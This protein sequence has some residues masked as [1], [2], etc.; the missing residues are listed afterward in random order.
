LEAI[1]GG[2]IQEPHLAYERFEQ[3]LGDEDDA[4]RPSELRVRGHQTLD[5]FGI[6]ETPRV[7]FE[8]SHEHDVVGGEAE[9]GQNRHALRVERGKLDV[10][11]AQ[12]QVGREDLEVRL[13][14]VRVVRDERSQL[15]QVR[16]LT[17][18]ESSHRNIPDQSSNGYATAQHT[19]ASTK[20]TRY[21]PR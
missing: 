6:L 1:D 11:A 8:G 15:L 19:I 7:R 18:L 5:G 10:R 14:R 2:E 21:G 3:P 12:V 17:A 16:N 13:H 20:T 4:R 9:H